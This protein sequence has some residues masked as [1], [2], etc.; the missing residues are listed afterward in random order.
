[1]E[2]FEGETKDG[3]AAAFAAEPGSEMDPS[4]EAEARMGLDREGEGQG[5]GGERGQKRFGA[6]EETS[7]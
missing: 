7:A 2:S 3:T 1:V 4:R 6:L 5:D